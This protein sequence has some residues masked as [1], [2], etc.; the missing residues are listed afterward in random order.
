MKLALLDVQVLC[1]SGLKQ[2]TSAAEIRVGPS[3]TRDHC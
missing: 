1:G 3:E 2:Q